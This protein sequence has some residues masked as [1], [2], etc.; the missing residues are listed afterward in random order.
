MASPVVI[1]GLG[2]VSPFGTS[3][4]AFRDAL[5]GGRTAVAPL[6]AFEIDACRARCAAAV[7]DFDAT[8]WIPV[9]KLRRMDITGQY[10]IAIARQALDAAALDYGTA[11]DDGVGV[12]VGTYTAG[13]SPTE[14]FLRALF[15]QGPLGA[16]ALIFNATVANIAASLV[17]L[18]LKLRGPNATI[19]HKEVSGLAAIAHGADLLRAGHG[20][21]VIGAGID[22]LYP[23]FY[24][25]HDRFRV[26]SHAN[27]RPEGSRPFDVTRNGFVL[28]EGGFAVVLE[29]AES[30]RARGGRV[31]AELLATA[32][33]G[34]SVGI[35]QW[36]DRPAPLVRVMAAALRQA[37]LTPA[38]VDVVY[39]SANSTVKLD[40]VEAAALRELFGGAGRA[41][42]TSIKG[43]IGESGAAGAAACVAAVVCGRAGV[44][45]PIAGLR[46]P[47]ASCAGLRL[48]RTAMP[49][50]GPV[51][52]VNSIASGGALVSAV[53]RV[54]G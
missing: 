11:P 54:A 21:V 13:G 51:A 37:G 41:V 50:P 47:D 45:P 9:M 25:V 10:A 20:R 24:K 18:E 53:L 27:G 39:A 33:G 2:I 26:L 30:A 49:T 8:R 35:N 23:L 31:E 34:A 46:E 44:V 16:P 36:P 7:A 17:G 38:G 14:E 40:A 48:A 4:D 52:L 15:A 19:S 5:V 28:G 43:A 1:T 42:V 32:S 12:V 29:A 22:A 6:T 3:L